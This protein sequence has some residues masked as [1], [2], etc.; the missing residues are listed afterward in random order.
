MNHIKMGQNA[1]TLIDGEGGQLIIFS[2]IIL[3]LI[4]DH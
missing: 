2:V 1:L 4:E 3:F